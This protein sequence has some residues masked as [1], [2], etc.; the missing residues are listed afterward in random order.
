MLVPVVRFVRSSL[1]GHRLFHVFGAV[2]G[3]SFVA[4]FLAVAVYLPVL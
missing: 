4:F 3:L 1:R 2:L